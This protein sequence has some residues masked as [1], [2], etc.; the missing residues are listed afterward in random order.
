MRKLK[1]SSL[2]SGSI[3]T[4]SPALKRRRAYVHTAAIREVEVDLALWIEYRL[5]VD[6]HIVARAGRA[7]TFHSFVYALALGLPNATTLKA[8]WSGEDAADLLACLAHAN[9]LSD[10]TDSNPDEMADGKVP[11]TPADARAGARGHAQTTI[12]PSARAHHRPRRL[13]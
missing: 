13:P 4:V 8:H 9:L 6:H 10:V 12:A 5:W 1:R 3:C 11:M 2:S 7:E